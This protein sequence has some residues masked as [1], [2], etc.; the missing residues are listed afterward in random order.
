MPKDLP[1]FSDRDENSCRSLRSGI[2]RIF[3]NGDEMVKVKELHEEEN[4]VPFYDASKIIGFIDF[5]ITE[6]VNI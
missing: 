4:Y 1:E 6:N 2:Y 5:M 3:K